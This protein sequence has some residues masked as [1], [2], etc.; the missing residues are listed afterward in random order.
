MRQGL[1]GVADDTLAD[2]L[3]KNRSAHPVEP[4]LVLD[5][6][7]ICVSSEELQDI[8][9]DRDGWQRFRQ[10]YPRSSG[11]VEYSCIGF[12][13][14]VTQALVYAGQQQDWLMG[15]GAYRLY[16]RWSDRWVESSRLL[17]WISR[18]M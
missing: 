13:V 14:Q 5:R 12:N 3:A 16:W 1:K 18:W 11:I 4:G 9:C 7:L 8:F 6:Q 2:Y 17:A 10:R 15:Y